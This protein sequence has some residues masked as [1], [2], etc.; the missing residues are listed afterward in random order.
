MIGVP[1][2]KKE[3]KHFTPDSLKNIE[4]RINIASELELQ[5]I[6]ECGDESQKQSCGAKIKN[7][8]F[9]KKK[10]R[11]LNDARPDKELLTGNNLPERMMHRFPPEM[12]GVPIED[13]DD[14][15]NLEY[16][17]YYSL[18]VYLNSVNLASHIKNMLKLTFCLLLYLAKR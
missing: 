11:Q 2:K 5:R 16:V 10:V 15:S 6:L 4:D 9:K 8:L 12:F 14:F 17:I 3:F 7:K 18:L 13:P 1:S